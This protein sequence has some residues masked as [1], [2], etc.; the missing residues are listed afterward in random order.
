MI[1]L[2]S[3]WILNKADSCESFDCKNSSPLQGNDT[4]K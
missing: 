1:I 2:H 3:N 4:N